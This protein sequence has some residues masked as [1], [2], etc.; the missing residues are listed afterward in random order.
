[1]TQ[2][3]IV[4]EG[5]AEVRRKPDHA[6]E[7]VSQF[8]LGSVL[9][10]LSTRGKDAWYRVEGDDGYTG[11][12][13]SWSLTPHSR[14]SLQAYRIGPG[15]EV[16]ALVGRVREAASGRS[17][18]MREAP[19][20]ARLRRLGRK[21]NWVRVG[22]PDGE[23]GFMH[24]R[25]LLIDSQTF[26]ARTRP[27]HVHGLLKTGLRMLGVPYQWGGVTPKGLDCSGLVQTTF[28][29][30]GV[31]LPRDSGDQFKWVKR[32]SYI[33]RELHEL[34]RGHLAFFGESDR[35]ITHVGIGVGD[36]QILHAQGRVRV[37]SLRPQDSDFNRPLFRLF[38]GCGPVLL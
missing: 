24:R 27:R 13:R 36:G 14:R 26:R 12:V 23:R 33:S 11:W 9:Q 4:N 7:Q 37:Q 32:E 6:A 16:E 29:A 15:V 20:G 35:K 28:A 18:A 25:D 19:L 1:M 5:V 2:Y 22:L 10:V 17:L 30:H 3:A 34:Q 38:R 8:I 31:R 21:G